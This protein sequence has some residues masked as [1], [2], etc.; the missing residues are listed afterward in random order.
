MAASWKQLTF[1]PDSEALSTLRHAWEW[2]VPDSYLAFMAGVA[3]DVFYEAN[4]GSIHWLS[5][6]SGALKEIATNRAT[7]LTDL[8]DD[9]GR[10][11][12]LAPIV[13]KLLEA[14]VKLEAG[15]C[16]G[17]KLLPILGGDYTPENMF[18]LSAAEWYGFS[19]ETHRQIQGLPD[20]TRVRLV[21]K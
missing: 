4:D 21:L 19:G 12:L 20:G 5:T 18:A 10:K 16:Y 13:D 15:Q 8:R 2:L 9:A 14:G 17:F 6:D 11:W 3:G 7:F 1:V